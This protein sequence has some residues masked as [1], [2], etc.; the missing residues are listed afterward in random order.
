MEMKTLYCI[1]FQGPLPFWSLMLRKE[2]P[3]WAS[4]TKE[5]LGVLDVISSSRA[6]ETVFQ[7]CL[8]RMSYCS[9]DC[10]APLGGIPTSQFRIGRRKFRSHLVTEPTMSRKNV[11]IKEISHKRESS[12]CT[13]VRGMFIRHSLNF[14]F[15]SFSHYNYCC[16]VTYCCYYVQLNKL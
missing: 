10:L 2:H 6:S 5:W 1:V 7:L 16:I 15:T 8:I 14:D 9:K 4:D 13:F 3:T 12:A 11:Q